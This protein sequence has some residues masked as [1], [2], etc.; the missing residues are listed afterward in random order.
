MKKQLIGVTGSLLSGKTT[1]SNIFKQKGFLVINAD[2]IGHGILKNKEVIKKIVSCF[3]R[4][5][6]KNNK[7]DRRRLSEKVFSNYNILKKL[8][9]ITHPLILK[10]IWEIINK[11][12]KKKIVID[13]PLL[14]ESGLYTK[15]DK[16][17]VVLID[18]SEQIKRCIKEGY[19][20]KE[21]SARIK[22]QYAQ[23][24]KMDF[25]DF[26]IDSSSSKKETRKQA[27]EI[28]KKL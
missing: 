25:A 26:I 8:N 23:Y 7:I 2:N 19:S 27:L 28:I 21:A 9:I 14:I 1:V 20:E 18:K 24:K 16:V 22:S 15:M 4:D 10:G 3:G 5:V 12:K 11:S 6:L 17:I 13:A